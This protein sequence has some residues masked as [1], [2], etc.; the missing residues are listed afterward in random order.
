MVFDVTHHVCRDVQDLDDAVIR[1]AMPDSARPGNAGKGD[2][3]NPIVP[4]LA[5]FL[6]HLR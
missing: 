5:D 3:R 6:W 2:D 1:L 4:Q